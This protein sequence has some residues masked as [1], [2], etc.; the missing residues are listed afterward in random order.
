MYTFSNE[1]G[2][3][4]MKCRWIIRILFQSI[5]HIVK[6]MRY[7]EKDF[8][9]TYIASPCQGLPLFVHLLRELIQTFFTNYFTIFFF[10]FQ[11]FIHFK[12]QYEFSSLCFR[13]V[14]ARLSRRTRKKIP[15]EDNES[16]DE[17]G[18]PP[19]AQGRHCSPQDEDDI[20]VNWIV[21]N[22]YSLYLYV[23]CLLTIFREPM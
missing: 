19:S 15:G 4:D 13:A 11:S 22:Q 21:W 23:H 20:K 12:I 6:I 16:D 9:S 1:K 14:I 3:W 17:D 10:F 18:A 7:F 5:F 8:S 2:V